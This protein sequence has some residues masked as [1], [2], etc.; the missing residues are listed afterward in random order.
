MY[1]IKFLLLN[2][3]SYLSYACMHTQFIFEDSEIVI[4][5]LKFSRLTLSLSRLFA[6]G[7]KEFEVGDFVA[8]SKCNKNDEFHRAEIWDIIKV[9]LISL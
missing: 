9:G 4:S 7:E 5:S 1:V 2:Y 3:A 8:V 6:E